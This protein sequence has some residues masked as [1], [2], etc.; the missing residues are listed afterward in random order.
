MKQKYIL[1]LISFVLS[2]MVVAALSACTANEAETDASSESIQAGEV[3]NS[4][5]IEMNISIEGEDGIPEIVVKTNLPDKTKLSLSLSNKKDYEKGTELVINGGEGRTTALRE[6]NG[7]L[8]GDYTLTVQLIPEKQIQSVKNVIGV[9]GERLEDLSTGK[10]GAQSLYREITYHSP[11][12][13]VR[14]VSQFDELQLFYMQIPTV[15]TPASLEELLQTSNLYY[16][17]S[18]CVINRQ[19]ATEHHYLKYTIATTENPICLYDGK[20]MNSHISQDYIV[21]VFDDRSLEL[22]YSLYIHYI[23]SSFNCALY[24]ASG[25]FGDLSPIW[26]DYT[27]EKAGGNYY[28]YRSNFGKPISNELVLHFRDDEDVP[29]YYRGKTVSTGYVQCSNAEEAVKETMPWILTRNGEA[30]SESAQ[31]YG[32]VC[33]IK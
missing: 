16:D 23:N 6:W 24:Y 12:Q 8:I 15:I 20:V 5:K 25:C 29:Y 14:D 7:R 18:H 17:K 2:L 4:L 31:P 33:Y 1:R 21:V 11:Y 13:Q 9:N 22:E 10:S 30:I 28:Y 19:T 27:K 26:D 3:L 32:T